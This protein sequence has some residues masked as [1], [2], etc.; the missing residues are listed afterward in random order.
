MLERE[1][2]SRF[3]LNWLYGQIMGEL[4]RPV[5]D[6]LN[7]LTDLIQEA[8]DTSPGADHGHPLVRLCDMLAG[9]LPAAEAAR[10]RQITTR[11][12]TRSTTETS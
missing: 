8:C 1:P 12:E 5:G 11:P 2:E 4:A 10:V 7:G 6:G 3:N 9:R